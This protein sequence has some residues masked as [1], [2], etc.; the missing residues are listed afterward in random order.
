[1]EVGDKAFRSEVLKS[2]DVKSSRFGFEPEI[3]VKIAKRG[4]RTYEVPTS[5]YGRTYKEGEKI[6]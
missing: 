5:Y 4:C 2:I 3:T 6:T 1:M